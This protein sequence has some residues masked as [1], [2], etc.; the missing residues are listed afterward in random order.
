MLVRTDSERPVSE[1]RKAGELASPPGG[2]ARRG[3]ECHTAIPIATAA[4]LAANGN[5]LRIVQRE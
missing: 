1:V 4:R 3:A 5:I 2:L